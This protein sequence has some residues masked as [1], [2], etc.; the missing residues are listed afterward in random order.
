M[1]EKQLLRAEF[2]AIRDK[3]SPQERAA[4]E[5]VLYERL[6]AM[7][8]WEQAPVVC[9]YASV[10]GEP[11]TAPI[12]ARAASEG[13]CLALPV[14]VTGAREGRMI[15]RAVKGGHSP[16]IPARFGIPE[17]DESCPALTPA[18]LAGALILVP[19]LAFDRRGFRVGYGG[20]Y[21]DR[22][23]E[24]LR[25][26]GV[27]HVTAGL[28]F[29]ACRAEALPREPHDIPVDVIIDERRMTLSHEN[30]HP[31]SARG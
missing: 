25:T 17:P 30:H 19:G 23:L 16:L 8:A 3:L 14:T 22:F 21:Y 20:G 26:A 6:F 27:P 24:S 4:A 31:E 1:T 28:C 11:D 2:T 10:K 18:D 29:A 12:L 13:K 9:G 5:T 15:F 7:T